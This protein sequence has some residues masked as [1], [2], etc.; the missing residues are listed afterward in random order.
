VS[1]TAILFVLLNSAKRETSHRIEQLGLETRLETEE[2]DMDFFIVFETGTKV[3]VIGSCYVVM[4]LHDL[5]QI[6]TPIIIK[7]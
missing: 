5:F 7:Q 2:I 4:A 3:I 6:P 1:D